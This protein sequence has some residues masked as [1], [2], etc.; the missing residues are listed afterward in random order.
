L[1][2]EASLAIAERLGKIDPGN[3]DWQRDVTVAHR[4][5]SGVHSAQGDLPAALEGYK[6][7]LSIRDRLAKADPSNASSQSDL[8]ASHGMR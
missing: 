5:I 4:R 2:D 8:S 1:F 7:S 6:I 3:A